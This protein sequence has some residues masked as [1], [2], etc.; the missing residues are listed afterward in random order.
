MS[1][2]LRMVAGKGGLSHPSGFIAE[3]EE[4]EA[5]DEAQYNELSELGFAEPS[6]ANREDTGGTAETSEASYEAARHE[7]SDRAS[8][9]ESDREEA[10]IDRLMSLTQTDLRDM[11]SEFDLVGYKRGKSKEDISEALIEQVD[12]ETLIDKVREK[13]AAREEG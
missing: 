8:A 4:F 9:R 5:D 6:G 1:K 13:E 2:D 12:D 10:L 3:G 7:P 11:A